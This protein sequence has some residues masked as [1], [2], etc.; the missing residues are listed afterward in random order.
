MDDPAPD[1]PMHEE[2]VML[3]RVVPW[4]GVLGIAALVAETAFGSPFGGVGAL[5]G[6]LAALGAYLAWGIIARNRIRLTPGRL[7]VGRESYAPDDFDRWFGVQPRVL[8]SPEEQARV[9]RDS[10]LPAD[11]AIRVAGGGWGRLP[12]TRL[13][14]VRELASGD[15]LAIF[16]RQPEHFATELAAWMLGERPDAGA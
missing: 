14:L 11:A 16:S 12:G 3:G 4:A 5:V 6:I 15:V 13:V 7:E 1:A 9:E 10:P 2:L 8:L